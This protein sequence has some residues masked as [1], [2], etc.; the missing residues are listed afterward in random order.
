MTLGNQVIITDVTGV[1]T[2]THTDTNQ[3]TGSYVIGTDGVAVD[4][5]VI[6]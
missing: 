1:V 6:P 3:L 5:L 4:T 2:A